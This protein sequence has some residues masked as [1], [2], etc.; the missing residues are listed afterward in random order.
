MTDNFTNILLNLYLGET[1]I[2]GLL[3]GMTMPTG[4]I[5]LPEMWLRRKL[6]AC[7]NATEGTQGS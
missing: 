2:G 1:L 3:M 6:P 7:R 5:W 4:D